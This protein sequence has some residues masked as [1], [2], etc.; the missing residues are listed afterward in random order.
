VFGNCG[1]GFAPLKPGAE[2]YLINLMEGVED[3]PEVVLTAGMEF[4]WESFADYLDVLAAKPRVMDVGAQVPHG[5]LRFYVMGERGADHAQ[6]PDE[7]E[8]ARMGVLLEEALKAGALGFTTARTV[9]HRAADGR[10]T[11]SRS[12]GSAELTGLAQ[13]MRRAA[14]GVF[15]ANSDF[16]EGEFERL[17]AFAEIAGRPLSVGLVQFSHA[18]NLWRQVLDQ[19]G[20]AN[21]DGI[22]A[23]AQVGCRPIGMMLGLETSLNPFKL[24]PEWRAMESLA[25]ARRVE[26]LRAD[27]ALRQR[28]VDGVAAALPMPLRADVLERSY[29]LAEP[30]DYEPTPD[31]TVAAQARASGREPW[32]LALEIMLRQGGKRLLMHT[33][34]N[35]AAGSLD[36]VREMLAD[37]HTVCG[38]ADAGA[39]V[40]LICDAGASTFLLTHWARDRRRGQGFPLEFL[41]RKHSRV[42]AEHYGL[43]DRGL[44]APGHR[45]DLNVIDFEALRLLPPEL[46]Y[47]LPAGGKRLIQKADGYRHTFVAGTETQRGGEATGELPGRL[48]RGAQR[49]PG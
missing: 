23:K 6:A 13:A 37:E 49:A 47:D 44:V 7:A 28:L 10:P 36:V 46:V 48:I 32:A 43:L 4:G 29:E 33:F 34:E 35:Y 2:K 21:R 18:P 16:D 30:L 42:N 40:G 24:L 1:V 22:S 5:A 20:R 14:S 17:R 45:A 26:R 8:I 11:P 12:A 3:I 38:A 27:A 19:V 41:V 15:E 31:R 25:P 9:K 39:H